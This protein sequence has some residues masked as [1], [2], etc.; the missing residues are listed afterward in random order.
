MKHQLLAALKALKDLL[1]EASEFHVTGTTPFLRE[2]IPV[3]L[4][5]CAMLIERARS[6][7]ELNTDATEYPY[8]R[9]QPV[10]PFP[11]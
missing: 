1:A 8:S 11:T 4:Q 5:Q 3:K 7:G 2:E 6:I 10:S 9:F